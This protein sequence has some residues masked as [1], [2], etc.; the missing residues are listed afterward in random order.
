VQDAGTRHIA[1]CVWLKEEGTTVRRI[2]GLIGVTLAITLVMVT[3]AAP[4]SAGYVVQEHFLPG[5]PNN[6]SGP[7]F[8]VQFASYDRSDAVGLDYAMNRGGIGVEGDGL[9]SVDINV[10]AQRTFEY[11]SLG[12]LTHGVDVVENAEIVDNAEIDKNAPNAARASS[13]IGAESDGLEQVS[14]PL[15]PA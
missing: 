14:V 9:Y 11:D 3:W 6:E 1:T 15:G 2:I 7:L 4:A 13:A 5:V 12:R 8:G 10:S